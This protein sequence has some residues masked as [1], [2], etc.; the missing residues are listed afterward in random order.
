MG[1][2]TLTPFRGGLSP[3]SQDLTQPTCQQNLTTPAFA[4]VMV[5]DGTIGNHYPF[6]GIKT[7]TD[8]VI[9]VLNMK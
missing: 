9:Y 4:M 1:H 2:V 7:T 6:C 5:T 3:D 8:V